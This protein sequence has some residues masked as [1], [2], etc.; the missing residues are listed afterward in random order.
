MGYSE[1]SGW[2]F[3]HSRIQARSTAGLVELVANSSST[4][5]WGTL[6]PRQIRALETDCP[7]I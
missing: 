1:R 6:D 2:N 3:W 7:R 5:G 4:V